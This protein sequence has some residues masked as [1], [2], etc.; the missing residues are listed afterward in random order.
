MN[1]SKTLSFQGDDQVILCTKD[2][3]GYVYV[4]NMHVGVQT[5]QYISRER[6]AYGLRDTDG[7]FKWFTYIT[8]N[9]F[10]HY[11]RIQIH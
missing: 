3:N 8:V 4:R 2:A 1:I 5:P 10:E 9:L 11:Y 7:L 6:P